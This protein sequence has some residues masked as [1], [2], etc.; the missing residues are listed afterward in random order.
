MNHCDGQ[1]FLVRWRAISPNVL[2]DAFWL[3][4]D[5]MSGQI[6]T[7]NAGWMDVDGCATPTF[8]YSQSNSGPGNL[9]TITA[10]IQQWSAAP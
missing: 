8:H 5:G 9:A 6:I 2:I 7:T 3:G 10:E 1:R 4:A